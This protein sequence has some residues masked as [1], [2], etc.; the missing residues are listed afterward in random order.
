MAFIVADIVPVLVMNQ[1]TAAVLPVLQVPPAEV[2]GE[3]QGEAQEEAP[4]LDLEAPD[5]A[6]VLEVPAPTIDRVQKSLIV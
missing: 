4:V 1:A 3:A 5:Q 2:Q 6:P